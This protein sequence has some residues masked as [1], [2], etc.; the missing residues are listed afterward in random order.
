MG[1]H[2]THLKR[3]IESKTLQLPIITDMSKDLEIRMLIAALFGKMKANY[4][5]QRTS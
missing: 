2:T 4:L 1:Y 3:G 5:K